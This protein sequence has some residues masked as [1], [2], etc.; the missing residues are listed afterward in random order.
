MIGAITQ[1]FWLFILTTTFGFTFLLPDKIALAQVT[2]E[3]PPETI[4]RPN[5]T[6]QSGTRLR[7]IL[8]Q[9]PNIEAPLGRLR[10]GA[11]RGLSCV[12]KNQ[13][14]KALLPKSNIGLTT[15]DNP[16][17]Y[18]FIPQTPASEIELIIQDENA[19][20]V[21]QQSY[22]PSTQAGI[23]GLSLPPNTISVG[24]KYQWTLAIICDSQ[25]RSLDS[26]IEGKTQ[27]VANPGLM[28]KLEQA[29]LHERLHLYA[30]A[31][32]WYDVLDTLVKLRYANPNDLQ[33]KIDWQDLLTAPGV[34]LDQQLVQKPLIPQQQTPQPLKGN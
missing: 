20:I 17:L 2:N 18:L 12:P 27:R 24:K 11:S 13:P 33:L 9:I 28:K 25:D 29:T 5:R 21:Y 23:V 34:E 3:P 14:L 6:I 22:K 10:G 7:F 4:G 16:T 26:I 15:L 19:Q 8:P 31:G 32:I 1:K 30:E